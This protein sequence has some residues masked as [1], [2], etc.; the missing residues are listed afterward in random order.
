M[1][2]PT[3]QSATDIRS[4][5][6]LV[7]YITTLLPKLADH[8]VIL[9]PLT[10]KDTHKK[11]PAWTDEHNFAFEPINILVCSAEWLTIVD[12]VN[13]GDNKIFLTCD[14]SDWRTGTALSFGPMWEMAQPVAFDSADEFT[15]QILSY[16]LL[17]LTFYRFPYTAG[18]PTSTA[19]TRPSP[20]FARTF[21][22]SLPTI[23]YTHRTIGPVPHRRPLI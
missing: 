18:P 21:A 16:G 19:P 10:T 8:T 6:G 13:P 11:F 17:F 4:F 9:T 5:L 7:R 15:Q 12:H 3:P 20:T 1:K 14:V 22:R 2:W 23:P